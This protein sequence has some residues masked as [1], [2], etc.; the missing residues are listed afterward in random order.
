MEGLHDK[1]QEIT[2][3]LEAMIKEESIEKSKVGEEEKEKESHDGDIRRLE[4]EF[5]ADVLFRLQKPMLPDEVS[6]RIPAIVQGRA[7]Y[8]T[9]AEADSI[10]KNEEVLRPRKA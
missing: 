6:E 2:R 9:I 5:E 7:A 1:E 8:Q 3:Q 10:V 4:K